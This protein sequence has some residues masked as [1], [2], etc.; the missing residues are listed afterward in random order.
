MNDILTFKD[1]EKFI[2]YY[3]ELI[4]TI[5]NKLPNTTIYIQSIL[6][7]TPEV[8]SNKPS[9]TNENIDIFN[10][11]IKKMAEEDNIEYLNI[12]EIL[13]NNTELFE[14][15]GIHVKYKFY[16]LWLE[17]LTENTK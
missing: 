10:H 11:A 6:P 14:P 12:R 3:K 5:H 7:V 2:M 8:K 9:L 13:E 1:S 17:Y 4:D 16:E 15:D